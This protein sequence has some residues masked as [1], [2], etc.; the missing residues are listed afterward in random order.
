MPWLTGNTAAGV[1]CRRV[2]I[3][4]DINLRAAFSGALLDL[5]S[6]RNWEQFGTLTPD[7]CAELF[8]LMVDTFFNDG[9]CEAEPM[10]MPIGSIVPF[11]TAAIPAGM[12]E[13]DGATYNTA[14]YPALAALLDAAFVISPTEFRVP[15]LRG[16]TVV[17]AGIGPG[18]TSRAVGDVGGNET[19]ILNA[20]QMPQ[21]SH[22]IA[23][24]SHALSD[25]G[26]NH[27]LSDPGHAH[28]VTDFGHA[29]AFNTRGNATNEGNSIP[30]NQLNSVNNGTNSTNIAQSNVVVNGNTTSIS[31][32]PGTTGIIVQASS[33]SVSNAGSDAA[34]NNMQPFAALRYAIV[35][36]S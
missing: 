6:S 35:A 19:H 29:H 3:P 2:F 32:S 26:H 14:D 7:Q 33:L 1:I 23:P 15:D 20:T 4:A 9:E 25:P 11:A 5:T 10:P 22:T 28:G 12:L 27:A 21:H 31:L 18:L 36:T 13:C 34:H 24:H 17:G 8:S 16:R 30:R